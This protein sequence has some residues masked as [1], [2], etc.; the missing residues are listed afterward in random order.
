MMN[1]SLNIPIK[2]MILLWRMGVVDSFTAIQFLLNGAAQ[3]GVFVVGSAVGQ[4]LDP[5]ILV[6]P[7]AQLGTAYQ[8]VR[9]AQG[10]AEAQKRAATIALL[11]SSST[12]VLETD[13]ATNGAMAALNLSFNAYINSVLEASNGGSSTFILTYKAG[14]HKI[15]LL[16]VVGGIVLILVY[17]YIKLLIA[18]ARKGWQIEQSSNFHHKLE[19]FV[20]STHQKLIG[21][22]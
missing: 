9:A 6:A 21:Y 1:T 22:T 7:I 3:Y 19:K 14:Q 11:L 12:A 20:C 4:T 2:M 18:A 5:S 17:Y 10:A 8:Y 16:Y 15:I 13:L